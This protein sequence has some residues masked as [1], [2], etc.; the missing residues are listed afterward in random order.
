MPRPQ[1]EAWIDIN[2][3]LDLDDVVED[4]RISTDFAQPY[5]DEGLSVVSIEDLFDEL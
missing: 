3:F 4:G 1:P 5:E 2:A